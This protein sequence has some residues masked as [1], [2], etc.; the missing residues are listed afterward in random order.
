MTT[1][2]VCAL[3]RPFWQASV[4]RARVT[5]QLPNRKPTCWL[6]ASWWG[7]RD[8][9]Q[10]KSSAVHSLSLSLCPSTTQHWEMEVC[11]CALHLK[12]L[13]VSIR[14]I[15]SINQ[16]KHTSKQ[17]TKSPDRRQSAHLQKR[18]LIHACS[19]PHSTDASLIISIL[20]SLRLIKRQQHISFE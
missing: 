4:V 2:P 20:K 6:P 3:G 9:D 17:L 11:Y 13:D 5:P 10:Y 7:T 19:R 18:Q 12:A 14:N 16:S 15:S 1:S 8:S